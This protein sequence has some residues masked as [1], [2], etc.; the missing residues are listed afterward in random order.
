MSLNQQAFDVLYADLCHARPEYI[1]KDVILCPICLREIN[2]KM[3]LVGGVEHI[4][5]QVLIK[6][7]TEDKK[8]LGTMNQR[9]GITVLCREARSQKGTAKQSAEGCNGLK[10]QLYDRLW[11]KHWGD[12]PINTN[13]LRHR[14][15]VAILTMAYL[16]AFQTFGYE[17][18]L[19]P[20]LDEIR[21]QFDFPDDT[22]TSYLE[23]AQ[24][25]TSA[26]GDTIVRTSTGQPFVTGGISVDGYPLQLIFRR[27]KAQLPSG[28]WNVQTGVDSLATL[29]SDIRNED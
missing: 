18:I 17:Y 15:G 28:H 13:L 27:F 10:G 11:K 24:V 19:R 6:S 12:K 26:S 2:K 9:C 16:G 20:E 25:N 7:D 1:G 22:K 21:R 8:R 4:I 23:T 5:P 29:L 14:H 3:V